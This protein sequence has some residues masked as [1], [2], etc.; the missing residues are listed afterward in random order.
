MNV[1]SGDSHPQPLD[2]LIFLLPHGAELVLVLTGQLLSLDVQGGAAALAC[3]LEDR[4]R[5]PASHASKKAE[6]C[7]RLGAASAMSG[8]LPSVG[9]SRSLSPALSSFPPTP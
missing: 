5:Q 9:A 7:V 2:L 8:A 3:Q 6:G 4:R 1:Q